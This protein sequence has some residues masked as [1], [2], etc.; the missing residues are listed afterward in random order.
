MA[1][2]CALC[3][4]VVTLVL[5]A[6]HQEVS[7]TMRPFAFLSAFAVLVA[8]VALLAPNSQGDDKKTYPAFGTIE[9]KDPGFD[10]LIPKDA[11]LE[12]LADGFDWSEG[13]VWIKDG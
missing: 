6:H 3:A 11:I 10:K 1:F 12:N 2:L 4:S 8:A 13:P 9:R 5:V 7:R